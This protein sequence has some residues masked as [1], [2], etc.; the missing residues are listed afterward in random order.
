MRNNLEKFLIDKN[1]NNEIFENSFKTKYKVYKENINERFDV[2][3]YKN[4]NNYD[5]FQD[6]YDVGGYIDKVEEC[7][8]DVNYDLQNMFLI[9]KKIKIAR[10][11]DIETKLYG[12]LNK[13]M[14]SYLKENKDMIK[15]DGK[16]NFDYLNQY[17]VDYIKEE[18][19]RIYITQ[20]NPKIELKFKGEQY[21]LTKLSKYKIGD[22]YLNYLNNAEKTTDDLFKELVTLYKEE[23]GFEALIYDYKVK[24]LEELS[25]GN[26]PI[27]KQLNINRNIYQ[28]L[29]NVYARTITINIQYGENNM[30]FKYNLDDLK[31]ELAKGNDSASSYGVAY[32]KVSDFIKNNDTSTRTYKSSFEFSHINFITYGKDEIY[33]KNNFIKNQKKENKNKDYER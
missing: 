28:S 26:N 13:K 1:R 18:I 29:Q 7:L 20:E 24:Y 8:Y 23:L 12:E 14:D 21:F 33:N 32:D 17:E 10:F 6:R 22:I 15:K 4:I 30:N 11:K 27:N 2:I 31:R 5:L 3:Y 19:N 9:D 16:R 25:K